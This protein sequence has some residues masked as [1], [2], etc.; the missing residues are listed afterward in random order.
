MK[1]NSGR[2]FESERGVHP[3]ICT[4]ILNSQANA[5]SASFIQR[6]QLV[7]ES[8]KLPTDCVISWHMEHYC[9]SVCGVYV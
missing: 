8:V 6:A 4:Q 1:R 9:S 5:Y 2:A 7:A 3:F